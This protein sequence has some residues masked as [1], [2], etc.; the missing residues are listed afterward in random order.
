MATPEVEKALAD[1]SACADLAL[2][3]RVRAARWMRTYNGL[4]TP[5][6]Q[7]GAERVRAELHA[8]TEAMGKQLEQAGLEAKET[9]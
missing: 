2:S 4:C 9:A 5:Q 3:L 6:L 8:L 7:A 1:L